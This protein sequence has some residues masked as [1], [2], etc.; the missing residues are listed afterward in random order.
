MAALT[1]I[2]PRLPGDRYGLSSVRRAV[3]TYCFIF[4]MTKLVVG[5][6][7]QLH[8]TTCCK[9]FIFGR[10]NG[11]A[12]TSDLTKHEDLRKMATFNSLI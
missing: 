11:L 5:N 4:S 1:S 2:Q 10:E 6:V 12:V 7:G 3:A 9:V 8:T